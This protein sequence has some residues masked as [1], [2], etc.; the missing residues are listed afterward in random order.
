MKINNAKTANKSL[1]MSLPSALCNFLP[2]TDQI[3]SEMFLTCQN[4][5]Y[6]YNKHYSNTCH[7][8]SYK[9]LRKYSAYNV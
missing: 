3:Q 5:A 2:K 8:Y 1:N 7:Y 4:L 9:T 6:F